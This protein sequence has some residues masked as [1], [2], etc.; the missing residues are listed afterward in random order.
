MVVGGIVAPPLY[1]DDPVPVPLT[2]GWLLAGVVPLPGV[3][4]LL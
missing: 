1:G 2:A 4:W 3:V